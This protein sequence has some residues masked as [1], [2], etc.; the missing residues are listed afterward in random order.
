MYTTA[1]KH[2]P[3]WR[4]RPLSS[5]LGFL[6]IKLGVTIAL[7]FALLNKVAGVYGLIAVLTGA[8]G[9]AAQLSLYIYSVIGLIALAWGLR[10]ITH[11]DP[12][13]TLYFAHV[14]FA[15]HVLSTAW[16]VFFAVLWWVYTPHDGKKQAN[17]PA[18]QEMAKSTPD[19]VQNDMSEEERVYAAMRM[20]DHE[21]G[22]ATTVIVLGWI[23][24][25]YFALL[26]Y[27]YASHLR[28]GSYRSL[29]YTRQPLPSHYQ[30]IHPTTALPD[31]EEEVDDFY[32][33]PVRAPAPPPLTPSGSSHAR[34]GS[35]GGSSIGSFADFV[36]A[37]GRGSRR[38]PNVRK[39]N[40][41]PANS[42]TTDGL[43]VDEVLFDEDEGASILGTITASR[44]ASGSGSGSGSGGSMDEERA[45]GG[46]NHGRKQSRTRP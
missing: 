31:E 38:V 36:S 21:K 23:A 27:S 10:A 11:E 6:D 34:S 15:D 16:T 17:S 20:W 32:R 13:H 9:S 28:K 5:F 1:T 29:P 35:N 8:G 22:M 25:I 12:K 42:K 41:N 2:S 46:S 40:L 14:F 3:E 7:L 37:P 33:L 18:Q 44:S 30:P 45:V 43:E 4:L 19:I 39:S 26:L 24:K